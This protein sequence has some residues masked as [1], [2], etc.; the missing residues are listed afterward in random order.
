MQGTK[1]WR[2]G[3]AMFGGKVQQEDADWLETAAREFAEE[4]GGLVCLCVVSCSI[5]W[6]CSLLTARVTA[7]RCL[8]A[9]AKLVYGCAVQDLPSADRGRFR[10]G[11]VHKVLAVQVSGM[12]T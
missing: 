1:K 9:I 5:N 2:R 4:T 12:S 6:A 8:Q 3:L 11:L 7:A 10:S